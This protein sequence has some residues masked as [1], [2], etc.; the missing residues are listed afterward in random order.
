MD[1]ILNGYKLHSPMQLSTIDRQWL[2]AP[3]NVRT[4]ASIYSKPI[5]Q[6]LCILFSPMQHYHHPPPAPH[7]YL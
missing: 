6:L 2:P 1:A 3:T 5:N 4:T 7:R